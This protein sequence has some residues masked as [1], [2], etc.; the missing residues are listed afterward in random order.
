M[1]EKA[2]SSGSHLRTT[3]G[4][5]LRL[6]WDGRRQTGDRANTAS[7]LLV[8]WAKV[9][10]FL[11]KQF[12]LGW[13]TRWLSN[14]YSPLLPYLRNLQFTHSLKISISPYSPGTKGGN[15]ANKMQVKLTKN[16]DSG[17]VI[18]F[19]IKK[20]KRGQ[21]QL[22]HTFCLPLPFSSCLQSR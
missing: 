19:L 9:F 20:K 2:C 18:H 5:N 16:I 10:L 12:A 4:V 14:I 17:K 13:Q 22:A 7:G 6:F 15:V 8:T 21:T 11:Y 1:N 3:R